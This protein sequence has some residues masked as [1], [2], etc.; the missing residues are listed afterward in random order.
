MILCDLR[1]RNVQP[2]LGTP[3]ALCWRKD[4]SHLDMHALSTFH[5]PLQER[6]IVA[7]GSSLHDQSQRV[8]VPPDLQGGSPSQPMRTSSSRRAGS[9]AVVCGVRRRHLALRCAALLLMPLP[10]ASITRW[11][12]DIGS[13]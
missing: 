13:H 1:Q 12:E 6:C 2:K 9:L 5:N 11:L 3:S 8:Y 4:F 10:K 7:P